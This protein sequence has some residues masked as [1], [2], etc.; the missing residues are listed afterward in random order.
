VPWL[1]DGDN[2][3]GTWPGHRRSD[4]ERRELARAIFRWAVRERRRA[5]VVF[6]GPPPPVPPPVPDVHFPGPGQDA[7]GWIVGFLRRV[8]DVAGW[9]V[10]TNDRPLGDQCRHLGARLER[11]GRFRERLPSAGAE[12]PE[13]PVDV[14]AWLELFGGDEDPPDDSP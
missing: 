1:V 3:L 4:A 7:D 14:E 11:C 8:R 13:G 5:V 6:D 12:K 2:L 9:T 10:V